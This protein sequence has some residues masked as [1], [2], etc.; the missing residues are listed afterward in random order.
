MQKPKH[1]HIRK[2]AVPPLLSKLPEAPKQLFSLG[3]QL[4]LLLTKP[5][6]AIVGSRKMSPYGRQ[7]TEKLAGDLVRHGVVIVSGLAYGVDVCAHK[8]VAKEGGTGIAVM[9]CGLDRIYPTA[10]TLI[11]RQLTDKGGVIIS[12]YEQGTPALRH[13]FLERN[14]LVS[15]LAD[16]VIITEAAGRSGTLNTAAHAINQGKPVLAVPGRLNDPLSEG[17]NNLIKSGAHL[18]TSVADVLSLLGIG[19][20]TNQSLPAAEN[21][22]EYVILKLIEQGITEAGQLLKQ[23]ELSIA[24]F[25]Q[26][27]T[28][29]EITSK[30]KPLGADNWGLA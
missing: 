3:G 6:V 24:V 12:E 5:R 26:T 22:A 2:L 9:A 8:T 20:S 19:K 21:Q 13:H 16:A 15:G 7:V 11:A 14:R 29:L 30:I 28:M 17:T 25:N 4:S 27:L 18:L 10:H 1:K 23:S